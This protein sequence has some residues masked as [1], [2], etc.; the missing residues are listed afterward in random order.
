MNFALGDEQRMMQDLAR[1]F[2][3]EEI[4][5][6]AAACDREARFPIEVQRKALERNIMVRELARVRVGRL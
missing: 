5:P 3:R 2:A 1:R 6:R 4:L